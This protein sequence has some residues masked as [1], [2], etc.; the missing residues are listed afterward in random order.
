MSVCC[1]INVL[2]GQ[3]TGVASLPSV[4]YGVGPQGLTYTCKANCTHLNTA[5]AGI[6]VSGTT[7][8]LSLAANATNEDCK[9]P[10][11]IVTGNDYNVISATNLIANVTLSLN[12]NVVPIGQKCILFFATQRFMR[13]EIV[14]NDCPSAI[15]PVGCFYN[16]TVGPE[17]TSFL[18]EGV[19]GGKVLPS[20]SP[21]PSAANN[22]VLSYV[23]ILIALI[24][25][26]MQQ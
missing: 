1:D 16:E 10:T 23:A 9:T 22:L 17:A 25:Y 6:S 4:T 3:Y 24:A 8:S 15:S 14:G 18:V 20:P 19:I 21:E 12:G 2:S 11:V 26:L 7:I 5:A 13:F